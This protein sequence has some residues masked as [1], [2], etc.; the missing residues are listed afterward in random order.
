MKTTCKQFYILN[1]TDADIKSIEDLHRVVSAGSTG[2]WETPSAV[3]T[4]HMYHSFTEAIN[5][6]I[7]YSS[8]RMD[9][10]EKKRAFFE[11]TGFPDFPLG[12]LNDKNNHCIPCEF[13]MLLLDLLCSHLLFVMT[14]L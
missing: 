5:E 10:L 8:Y 14:I 7:S 11:D 6:T 4:A 2:V 13:L 3:N 12:K 9:E 1:V